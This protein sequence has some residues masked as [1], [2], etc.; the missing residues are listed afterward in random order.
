M[1][2]FAGN[3][4]IEVV[5]MTPVPKGGLEPPRVSPPPPHKDNTVAVRNGKPNPPDVYLKVL[6]PLQS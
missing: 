1:V 2:K 4:V 5:N 3:F 6:V